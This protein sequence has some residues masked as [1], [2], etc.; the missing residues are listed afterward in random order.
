MHRAKVTW[1]M[2]RYPAPQMQ[3]DDTTEPQKRSS[4]LTMEDLENV[5]DDNAVS[6]Y[7]Q[8]GSDPNEEPASQEEKKDSESEDANMKLPQFLTPP[9]CMMH[10]EMYETN[11]H[12]C[13]VQGS[14]IMVFL[15]KSCIHKYNFHM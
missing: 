13:A 10:P 3:G 8:E 4:V 11:Q 1:P 9:K 15:L 12:V 2:R 7:K 5:K 14:D 6:D